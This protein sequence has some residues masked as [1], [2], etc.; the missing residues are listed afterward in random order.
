MKWFYDLQK[1][2]RNLIASVSWIPLLVFVIILG[3]S[4]STAEEVPIWQSI[5][6]V[7]FLAIGIFFTVFAVKANKAEKDAVVLENMRKD[8]ERAEEREKLRKLLEFDAIDDYELK[9]QYT[10]VKIGGV[11]I[12]ECNEAA[13]NVN[14]GDRLELRKEPTEANPNAVAVYSKNGE[15][16]GYLPENRLQDMVSDFQATK[17]PIVAIAETKPLKSMKLGFYQ[18]PKPKDTSKYET[19]RLTGNGNEDM[20]GNILN[21]SVDE[22]ISAEYD[23]DKEKFLVTD[24]WGLELGYLKSDTMRKDDT[25]EGRILEINEDE[26]GKYK[27]KVAIYYNF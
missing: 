27:V 23:W 5:L 26:N 15:R 10:D 24:Q 11:N 14:I 20:Q 7:L 8:K 19:Y 9:Y 25:Y 6:T 4:L 1:K 22:N 3:N 21:S 13:Y 17:C 16:V 12:P 2:Y 18:V